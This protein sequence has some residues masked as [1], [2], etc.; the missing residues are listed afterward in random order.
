MQLVPRK[1]RYIQTSIKK[2][3]IQQTT[4][5]RLSKAATE[6]VVKHNIPIHESLATTG[7]AA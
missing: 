5:K 6:T 7:T 1:I 2:F 4:R 3:I